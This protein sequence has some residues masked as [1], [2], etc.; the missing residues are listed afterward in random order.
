[1]I[2][3]AKRPSLG[4][5]QRCE[6]RTRGGFPWPSNIADEQLPN[7]IDPERLEVID[8]LGPTIQFLTPD[9]T[10]APCIMRGTIPRFT[11]IPIPKRSS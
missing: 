3:T 8:L 1:V 11:A 4:R 5:G 6:D 2:A 9:E 10:S 7:L